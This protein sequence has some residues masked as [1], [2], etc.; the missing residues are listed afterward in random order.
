MVKCQQSHPGSFRGLNYNSNQ[1]LTHYPAYEPSLE[2]AKQAKGRGEGTVWTEI[3][4]SLELRMYDP[5]VVFALLNVS[6]SHLFKKS[7]VQQANLSNSCGTALVEKKKK[8]HFCLHWQVAGRPRGSHKQ[9]IPRAG[10]HLP[11]QS[12]QPPLPPQE[13]LN[14]L[15]FD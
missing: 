14:N 4:Q 8:T 6:C 12:F 3:A 1:K 9:E 13:E 11:D 7:K 5:R 2:R 15:E 10:R